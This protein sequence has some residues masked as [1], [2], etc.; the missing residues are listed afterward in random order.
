MTPKP[1]TRSRTVWLN[2]LTI[3]GALAAIIGD[4]LNLARSLGITLPEDA[5]KWALLAVGV[6]NLAL[7]YRTT[8]PIGTA[9]EPNPFRV[10]P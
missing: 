5:V 6:T 9:P 8:Q 1:A 10:N 3:V 7:R 2:V 4:A